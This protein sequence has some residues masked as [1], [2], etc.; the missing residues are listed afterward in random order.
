M[1]LAKPLSELT[2]E[3]DP[4]MTQNPR[5]PWNPWT[6]SFAT[7][8]AAAEPFAT[9]HRERLVPTQVAFGLVA[10][11]FKRDECGAIQSLPLDTGSTPPLRE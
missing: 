9:S 1:R 2:S 8:Q 5:D 4:R 10:L 3:E 7:K 11:A 6:T